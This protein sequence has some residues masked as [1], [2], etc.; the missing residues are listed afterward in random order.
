MTLQFVPVD[1]TILPHFRPRFMHWWKIQNALQSSGTWTQNVRGCRPRL[2]RL[3]VLF[4]VSGYDE[5]FIS[6]HDVTLLRKI[7][8]KLAVSEVADWL[9]NKH[10]KLSKTFMLKLVSMTESSPELVCET[11]FCISFIG[12]NTCTNSTCDGKE[13]T[14]ACVRIR[15]AW[16]RLKI[17]MD[18]ANCAW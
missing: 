3:V 15:D 14:P 17:A 8:S 6:F 12:I 2:T 7:S 16:L 1:L 4:S 10:Q 18:T 11:T 13:Y 5:H 9:L